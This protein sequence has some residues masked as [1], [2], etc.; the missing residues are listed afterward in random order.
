MGRIASREADALY[1]IDLV[2]EDQLLRVLR[3]EL[4]AALGVVG[5]QLDRASKQAAVVVD[6]ADR[7]FGGLYHAP[8]FDA[9]RARAVEQAA[10]LDRL[11]GRCAPGDVGAHK[12]PHR[13]RC[14]ELQRFTT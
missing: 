2:L 11:R 6:L 9:E 7:E 5:D 13:R 10:Q 14:P 1:Y 4:D 8:A 3:I 12:C